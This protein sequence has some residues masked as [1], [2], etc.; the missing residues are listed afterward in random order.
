[1]SLGRRAVAFSV[2]IL[3]LSASAPGAALAESL[4]DV[5]NKLE[6]QY[7]LPQNILAKVANVESGGNPN[8]KAGSSSALGMFQWLTNSWEHATKALY[9][10]ALMPDERRNPVE[11]A[12]VTAFALA[13]AKAR[14]GGLIQ[15]AGVDMTLGL[16][17]SHFLGQAGASK[18]FQ[19]YVQNPGASAASL[20]PKEA[21]A[22]SSV[23]GGRTLAGVLNFFANK[24]KVAGVSVN[25][26][27]NFVDGNG[28]SLAYSTASLGSGSF[29]PASYT[30]TGQ[31][32][33][34]TYQTNYQTTS[35]TGTSGASTGTYFP[36]NGA[37]TS[38]ASYVA[39]HASAIIIAQ[40]QIV[41]RGVP[42]VVSW[43]SVG[44]SDNNPCA[45]QQGPTVVGTG[46]SMTR[47]LPTNAASAIGRII[48]TLSCTTAKGESA[49]Q[50][51]SVEIQ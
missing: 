6:Q 44:M 3:V 4:N 33:G 23:F 8:A 27:G 13:Q 20:F 1:M 43:A 2:L 36:S 39:I 15:Q 29:Y 16:Y 30:P 11:S 12:R 50:T 31:D 42:I 9:G 14:N 37:S 7:G 51:T 24:L 28:N 46:N 34:R 35:N 26:A 10:R 49:Q 25:I 47:V 48:F 18:F 32:P 22:N 17:M 41:K 5:F 38:T 21:G 19:A 40:P 45:V